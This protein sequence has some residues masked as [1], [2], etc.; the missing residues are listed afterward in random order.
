M[1][2]RMSKDKPVAR[3]PF[4]EAARLGVSSHSLRQALSIATL[5]MRQWA[6]GTAACSPP[7]PQVWAGPRLRSAGPGATVSESAGAPTRRR[8]S[9]EGL[10][11]K[12]F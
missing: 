7:T 12:P 6:Q 4:P 9:S 5:Q 10:Q 11:L 2:C 3:G 1:G 8:F